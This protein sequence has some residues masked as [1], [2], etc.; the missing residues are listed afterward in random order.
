M[1]GYIDLH[2]HWIPGIDD[3]APTVAEGL[4]ILRALGDAGFAKV[5]ATPHMR[6]GMF[7]NE[8][9]DLESAYSGMLAELA[10]HPGLPEVSL[11][12]EHHLDDLVFTEVLE[13]RGLPYEPSRTAALIEFPTDRF[14]TRYQERLFDLRVRRRIRP[15]LAHPERYRPVWKDIGLLE[16]L[17]DGGVVLLLDVCAIVGKYGRASKVAALELLEAGFYYAACTDTHRAEDVREVKK[18]IKELHAIMGR[19][20]AEFLLI[21]GPRNILEGR[22]TD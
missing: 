7:D 20:E 9:G 1:S 8:R 2:C 13:G 12:S 19:E 17:L 22:V 14:P 16:P 21:E 11:S 4:A 18:A 15:V 6:T 3:G 10:C 5:V